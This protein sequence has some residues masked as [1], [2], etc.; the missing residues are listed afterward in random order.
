MNKVYCITDLHGNYKL[1]EIVKNILDD[2]DILYCLGDNTDRGKDGVKI[3]LEMLDD[4]RVIL[5]KGNHELYLETFLED[6]LLPQEKKEWEL[7][8]SI[9]RYNGGQTTKKEIDDILGAEDGE[10]IIKKLYSSIKKLPYVE[11]YTNKKDKDIF[12]NHS[13]FSSYQFLEGRCGTAFKAMINYKDKDLK[14]NLEDRDSV[15]ENKWYGGDNEYIVFGHT[16]AQLIGADLGRPYYI[17][18]DHKIGLDMGTPA[19]N[20]IILFDLDHIEK[21]YPHMIIKE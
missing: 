6:L 13:G 21:D 9:W 19:S 15:F 10:E 16:P 17:C 2:T 12:L 20:M 5:L 8:E 11:L 7:D 4:D 18:E 1:W 14:L 3:T